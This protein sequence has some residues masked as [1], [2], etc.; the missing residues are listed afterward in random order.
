[1][2]LLFNE[3]TILIFFFAMIAIYNYSNLKEYQRM[4]I[5][6]IS[7]YALVV[8][9]IIGVKLALAFLAL[10]LFCFLEIFTPDEMKFSK[11]VI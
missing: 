5:I 10:S 9:N 1:M 2:E 11:S 8:F 3:N 4:A 7:I 6:Y